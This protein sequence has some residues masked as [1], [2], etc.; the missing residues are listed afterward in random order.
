MHYVAIGLT[1]LSGLGIIM[2]GLQYLFAPVKTAK[3]FGLPA[4]PTDRSSVGWLNVKGV[5]DVVSGLVVLIPLAL[6]QYEVLG[7]LLLAAAVTPIGDA[8]TILR[9]RGTKALAYAMHGGTA[10]GVI[11]AG[12]LFLTA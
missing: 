4:W 5:R 6:G 10:A 12:V 1:I 11:L 9:Y 8:L 2:V 3:T 7:Y